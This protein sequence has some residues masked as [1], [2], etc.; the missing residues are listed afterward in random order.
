MSTL[1][2]RQFLRASGLAVAGG[3]AA[4]SQS[5][6]R[7]VLIA[8]AGLAGLSA[9]YQLARAGYSVTVVEA[10]L[11]HGGRVFTL[12]EPFADGLYA[13]TGGEVAGDGYKRFLAYCREFNVAVDEV[14]GESRGLA[15][16]LRGKLYKPGEAINP[17]PYGLMGDEALPPPQLLARHL[18]AMGEDVAAAPAKLA[19]LD[20]LSLADAL[21]ARGASPQAI[22]LMNIS[23]NYS[24][25]STVSAA[26][27]LWEAARRARAGTK[28]V[29]VRGGNSRLTDALAAA[30]QRAGVQFLYGQA[31]IRVA[32]SQT[33]VLAWTKEAD[34]IA[35][36]DALQRRSQPPSGAPIEADLFIST[37]PA[38]TLRGVQFQPE[39]PREKLAA[40]HE[41]PYTPV[42]KIWLQARRAAWDEAGYGAGVWTDTQL[43]RVLALPGDPKSA[44]G[45]Y[46]VWL[47][48]QGHAT[49]AQD[50]AYAMQWVRAKMRETMPRFVPALEGGA[51][52]A[53]ATDPWAYG[54]Y[55]HFGKG[56]LTTLRPHLGVAHGRLHFAGEHTAETAPGMEGALESADRVVAEIK[57]A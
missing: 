30:A 8:G 4:R 16:M 3:M 15:T 49:I 46:V 22:E 11:R 9:A 5:A 38:T 50:A 14:A 24:H 7:R 48:G 35:G 28:V 53:W 32:H 55:A 29:R 44:R 34:Q 40:I 17:H 47:D 56:H 27:V 43:E 31:L 52:V 41:L 23:L 57:G 10:R 13:E 26:G 33:G 18:R 36:I 51:G 37:L 2:R 19:E 1:N 21:K 25:I 42:T 54:A 6:G 12:R 20:A 39:L 45:L